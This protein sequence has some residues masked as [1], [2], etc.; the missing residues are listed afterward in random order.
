MIVWINE[1]CIVGTSRHARLAADADRFIE[2]DDAV[3]AFEHR[4][5]G[6]SGSTWG[7]RALITARDLMG[8]PNLGPHSDIHVLYISPRHADGHDV[9]RLACSCAGMASNAASVVD[10]LGPLNTIRLG[11]FWFDHVA[12]EFAR[13]ISRNAN[14]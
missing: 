13:N 11:R 7:V 6:T 2:I 12:E 9:F 8:T 4:G 10:D 1:D 14:R 5:G 3:R